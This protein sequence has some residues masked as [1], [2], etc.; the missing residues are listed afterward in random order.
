[1]ET[2]LTGDA[3]VIAAR[4]WPSDVI[5]RLPDPCPYPVAV[6]A[7]AAAH[8]I[9]C[10]ETL[11]GYLTTAVH[12][13]VSVAVRLVPLGQTAGLQVMA[14]LES[15]VA[16][17]ATMAADCQP[18]RYRRHCL[19]RRYRPDA[20]RDPR[21][22][23]L[24]L[25]NMLVGALT[26]VPLLTVAFAHFL[27]A[28]RQQLADPRSD[29]CWRKLSS[30]AP[31]VTRMPNRLLTLAVALLLFAAGIIALSLA[32][33]DSGGAG[34]DRSRRRCWRSSL[35]AAASSATLPPGERAFPPSRSRRSIA[36][37]THRSACGSAPGF[38][39]WC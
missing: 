4:A 11:L 22:A 36:R 29:T 37:T 13:Q 28:R 30:G 35:S 21:N 39:F 2:A 5:A 26:F 27:W 19:C 7:I 33:H 34:P 1:M 14:G 9:G 15:A 24:P 38:S 18:R 32:D 8:G 16:G 12:A 3:F 10:P 17:L 31:G 6:G 25:M 23:S 20:A